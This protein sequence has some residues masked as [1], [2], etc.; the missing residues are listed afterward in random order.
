MWPFLL[1]MTKLECKKSLRNLELEAYASIITVFRAQGELNDKKRE[2]L[3]DLQIILH[4]TLDRHKAELRRAVNDEKLH[5]IAKRLS[6]NKT[7]INKKWQQESKRTVPVLP[8][9]PPSTYYKMIADQLVGKSKIYLEALTQPSDTEF[10]KPQ[11][12]PQLALK[13]P[14]LAYLNEDLSVNYDKTKRIDSKLFRE[15]INR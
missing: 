4:I 12:E 13:D 2:I 8:R 3:Q 14:N 7:N 15:K 11:K 5:T 9:I 6:S 10:K 1:D